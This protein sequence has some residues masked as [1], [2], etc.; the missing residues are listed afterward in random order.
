[1]KFY[2]NQNNQVFAFEE[3]GSQDD[4]IVDGLIQIEE[5]EASE[6]TK[7]NSEQ[8]FDSQDY[9]RK[10]LY[11]YPPIGEFIDAFIKGDAAAMEEYKK[12]CFAV[13]AKYPKDI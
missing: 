5:L 2:K 6:I 4:L 11:S 12:E 13:K 9:Y 10:R 3:D 8:L 1:M 7:R